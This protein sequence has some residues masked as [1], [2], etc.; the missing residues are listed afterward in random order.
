[1]AL[2]PPL[3]ESNCPVRIESE[4]LLLKRENIEFEI[5]IDKQE[6]F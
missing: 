3:D 6:T 1:M 2:N 4:T 5:D